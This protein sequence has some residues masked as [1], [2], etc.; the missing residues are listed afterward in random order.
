MSDDLTTYMADHQWETVAHLRIEGSNARDGALDPIHTAQITRRFAEK[1]LPGPLYLHQAEAINR[2]ANGHNVCLATGTASGKTTLFHCAAI[3]EFAKDPT[4]KVICLYPLK[5]LANEQEARWAEAMPMAIRNCVVGRIAGDVPVKARAQILRRSQVIVMTPDVMHSWLL[6]NSDDRS[7]R[8]FLKHLQ[9]VVIDEAHAYTGVF[10]SNSAFV[11]RRLRHLCSL[12]GRSPRFVAAS[13]TIADPAG[14]LKLLTGLEFSVVDESFNGAK[15]QPTAITLH[16]PPVGED[17]LST[18]AKLFQEIA[19]D[20]TRRMIAFVDSRKQVELLTSIA[21]RGH[22]E[23]PEPEPPVESDE[24]DLPAF[25]EVE[26][27]ITFLRRLSILP[28]RSGYEEEDRRLIQDRLTD[29]TLRGVISTSALELGIDIPSLDTAVLVGVPASSTSLKQRIGR[30]GRHKSGHVLVINTGSIYDEA[31]FANPERLLSRP[32][33]QSALYLNNQRIQYI[34]ALCL[35]RL[36]GEHD[37]VAGQSLEDFSFTSPVEWPLGFI[38]LCESERT[39]QIPVELQSMK[40]EAGESPNHAFPLRDVESSF[41]ITLK[42]GPEEYSLGSLTYSQCLRETYPGAVYRYATRS[43]RVYQVNVRSKEVRVRKEKGYVTKPTM[44]PTLVFPNLSHGN[45]FQRLAIGEL[46][47]VECNLQVREWLNGFAERRGGTEF[48]VAYPHINGRA[49]F[50]YPHPTFYRNYF[51]SGLVFFHPALNQEGVNRDLLA[52]LLFEAFLLAV[53]F[54]KSDVNKAIDKLRAEWEGIRKESRFVSIYDSTYG[55][56]HLSGKLLE[57]DVLRAALRNLGDLATHQEIDEAT[58][59]AAQ[60]VAALAEAKIEM[61][62]AMDLEPSNNDDSNVSVVMPGSFGLH[63]G[64]GN[65][66]YQ[67]M[68]IF[69]NPREDALCYKGRL[70]SMIAP[71]DTLITRVDNILPVP[72]ESRTGLYNLETGELESS[73]ASGIRAAADKITP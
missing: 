49:A 7:A 55:S 51:T 30:V 22:L 33:A 66:P 23:E 2:F 59:R 32:P 9:L 62:A 50:S 43:Y 4:A 48:G 56:L 57:Q 61:H 14:H 25:R 72:G 5:A 1:L 34:H 65:E 52:S 13:A 26:D 60:C 46:V 54:E 11:F 40:H 36:G 63:L 58:M 37:R 18:L 28:Y 64:R 73:E 8:A 39:G 15:R 12:L 27:S 3:E 71:E 6:P 38:G 41:K 70:D 24:D 47:A 67:V 20:P 16:N 45:I 69:W 53:P 17:L 19:A 35:A 29:G 44:L 42:N 31:V 21:A 68:S 10:G